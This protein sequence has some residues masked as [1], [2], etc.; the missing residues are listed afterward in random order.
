MYNIAPFTLYKGVYT[1]SKN[2]RDEVILEELRDKPQAIYDSYIQSY[3]VENNRF[4]SMFSIFSLC[5][6]VDSHNYKS[7]LS[8]YEKKKKRDITLECQLENQTRKYKNN[9]YYIYPHL[10]AHRIFFLTRKH[11]GKILGLL[12]TFCS[13][14]KCIDKVAPEIGYEIRPDE[15]N[16]GYGSLL[17]N[18]F[19]E[20]NNLSIEAFYLRVRKSNL[21]SVTIIRKNNAKYI[22][23][24]F[25]ED[26]GEEIEHYKI[27][28]PSFQ[29]V[30]K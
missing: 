7:I 9:N 29:K 12:D 3:G 25:A 27:A 11:D 1:V 19:L 6:D 20:K 13:Y 5:T 30:L 14:D 24:S 15:R 21:H 10:T 17:L 26:N 2:K 4:S 22:G 18:L 28:N 23:K 16:K 8:W